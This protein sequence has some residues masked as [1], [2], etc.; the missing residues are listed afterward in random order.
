MKLHISIGTMV[1][2]Y[3]SVAVAQEGA[4]QFWL[5]ALAPALLIAVAFALLVSDQPRR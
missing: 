5:V 2:G 1:A 4:L 3:V